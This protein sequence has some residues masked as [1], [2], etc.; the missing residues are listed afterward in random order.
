M[1]AWQ[2]WL[3]GYWLVFLRC[4]GLFFGAPVIGAQAIPAPLRLTVALPVAFAAYAGAGFPP[5]AS[6]SLYAFAIFGMLEVLLGLATGMCARLILMAAQGAGALAGLSMGIGFA[7]VLDPSEGS[8]SS[9]TGQITGTLAMVM[10]VALGGIQ[11]LVLWLG[12]SV[13]ALPPGTA[14]DI[15]QVSWTVVVAALHS[16][17]LAVKLA[18]PIMAAVL[19]GQVALAI[20]GRTA[21]QL[22]MSSLGFSVTIVAGAAISAAVVPQITEIAAREALAAISRGH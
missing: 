13:I 10:F 16:I 22:N 8:E 3:F 17:G 20:V 15:Q 1:E 5:D 18:Y 11:T 19:I 4:G 6:P 14:F 7:Q 21:P 12:R 2:P 9:S